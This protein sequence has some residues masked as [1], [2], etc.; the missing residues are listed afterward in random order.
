MRAARPWTYQVDYW[1][2][3]GIIHSML[4]GKYIT[5]RQEVMG[6]GNRKRYVLKEGLKRYWQQDLWRGLLEVL[7]NPT[8]QEGGGGGGLW[9]VLMN[10]RGGGGGGGLPIRGKWREGREKMEDWLEENSERGVGL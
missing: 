9:G 5:S 3:A 7:M 8:L 2:L 6:V 4:W 10:A 1:G